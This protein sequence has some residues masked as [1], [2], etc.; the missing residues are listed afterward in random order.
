MAVLTV[1]C[2]TG[3]VP[4]ALLKEVG[5]YKDLFHP[6]VALEEHDKLRA[7]LAMHCMNHVIK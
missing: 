7:I 6:H 2:T 3:S 4:A 5:S 1:L